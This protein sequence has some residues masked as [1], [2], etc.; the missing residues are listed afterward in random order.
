MPRVDLHKRA[1]LSSIYQWWDKQLLTI[2]YD[3]ARHLKMNLIQYKLHNKR[4]TNS[5]I[6]EAKTFG[7]D[8]LLTCNDYQVSSSLKQK[9]NL[10]LRCTKN[11]ILSPKIIVSS[12]YLYFTVQSLF[13][14]FIHIHLYIL[15]F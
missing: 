3:E 7:I 4:Y 9:L 10:V 8:Y 6:S 5:L 13:V 1:K 14:Y 15:L 2:M 11:H 12:S